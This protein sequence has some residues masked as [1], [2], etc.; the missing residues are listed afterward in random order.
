MNVCVNESIGY[1]II[2]LY[3]SIYIYRSIYI[4]FN[5]S[6]KICISFASSGNRLSSSISSRNV[7]IERGFAMPNAPYIYVY[8]YMYIS[9]Q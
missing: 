5:L 1:I 3:I 4:E 9:I 6:A 7:N 2:N 8:I